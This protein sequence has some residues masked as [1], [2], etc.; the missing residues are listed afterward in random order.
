M[1]SVSWILGVVFVTASQAHAMVGMERPTFRA[2]MKVEA[3]QGAFAP[4]SRARNVELVMTQQDGRKS[5]TGL[6]LV[7]D[8]QAT[9]LDIVA[10]QGDG[11][12]SRIYAATSEAPGMMK[13]ELTDHSTRVCADF[14]PDRWVARAKGKPTDRPHIQIGS[15]LTLVGSPAPVLTIQ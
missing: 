6:I 9:F 1:K 7:I 3:A 8:D 2:D 15:E 5:P 4:V 12:G 10:E 11:C 13:L 14:Q